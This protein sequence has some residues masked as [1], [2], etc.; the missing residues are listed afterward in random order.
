MEIEKLI[1]KD[2]KSIEDVKQIL[3][4]IVNIARNHHP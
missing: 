3:N 4:F 1:K 2:I